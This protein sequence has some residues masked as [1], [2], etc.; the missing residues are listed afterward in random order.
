[1]ATVTA[2]GPIAA[3]FV[4]RWPDA[5][6]TATWTGPPDVPNPEVITAG[7]TTVPVGCPSLVNASEHDPDGVP[8][9]F[10]ALLGSTWKSLP[11]RPLKSFDCLTSIAHLYEVPLHG[12]SAVTVAVVDAPGGTDRPVMSAELDV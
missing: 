12:R 4:I 10:P 2:T 5:S 3:G 7:L 1:M 9:R 6:R 8:D 11:G